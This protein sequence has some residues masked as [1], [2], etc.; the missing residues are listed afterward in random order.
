MEQLRGT[1]ETHRTTLEIMENHGTYHGESWNDFDG[2]KKSWNH[3]DIIES[4]RTNHGESWN[5][6]GQNE[7]HVKAVGNN[8]KSWNRSWRIMEQVQ[9]NKRKSWNNFKDTS[10]IVP[11]IMENHGTVWGTNQTVQQR[12]NS[13]KRMERIME[14]HG[15]LSGKHE[16]SWNDN[17]NY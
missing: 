2:N 15:T 9:R 16:N 12:G 17:G 11:Q 1:K 13:W 8:R 6:L 5:S 3:W 4:Q 10:K 14:N 7:N